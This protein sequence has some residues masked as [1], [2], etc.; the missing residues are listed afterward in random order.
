MNL[1]IILLGIVSLLTD[2]SSEMIMP[3]LPLF[4]ESVGATGLIIGLIGGLGDSVASILKVFSGFWSD[5][6]KKRK[7][8][9]FLGYGISAVAKL[10]FALAK[11]W[12]AILILRPIERVGKGVREAPRDA[13]IAGS[14]QK[15]NRGKGFGLHRAMDTTGAVFG[16]LIALLLIWIWGLSFQSIFLAAGIIAF[17]A[18]IPIF[19]VREVRN[20]KARKSENHERLKLKVGFK[21]LSPKL[22]WLIV[23]MAIFSLGNFTYMFFVLKVQSLFSGI[24]AIVFPILLYVLLMIFY[25]AFSY[26]IGHLSDKIGRKKILLAGYLL[27]AI[28]CLGFGLFESFPVYIILFIA[29]GI[30]FAMTDGTQRAYVSDLAEENVRGTALGTFHTAISVTT[31]PAGL[32][33]GW[34][35]DIN[36]D[37]PFYYG[38]VFAGI[39]F[40][41][42]L[43]FKDRNKADLVK[44]AFKN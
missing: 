43:F 17:F 8:F 21:K 38:A 18:L 25:A 15:S 7:P 41:G 3:I 37:Y 5:K 34:L 40:I 13:I 16:S 35:W 28:T 23:I 24:N 4:L 6:F 19:F 20:T 31:L 10:F 30:V 32:L 42:L 36:M 12:P 44:S 26:P 27:F 39:A 29:F 9:V 33:A 14:T 22:R 11:S 2:L 1:N